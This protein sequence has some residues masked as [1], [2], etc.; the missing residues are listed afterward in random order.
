ME[1]IAVPKLDSAGRK[2]AELANIALEFQQL[3]DA[4]EDQSSK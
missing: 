1:R 2:A 3:R 4:I